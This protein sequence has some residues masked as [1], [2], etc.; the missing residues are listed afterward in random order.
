MANLGALSVYL[1]ANT[2]QF[3]RK[4]NRAKTGI[5]AFKV[6]AVAGFTAV[7]V[8]LA[9]MSIDAVKAFAAQEKAENKLRATLK[10]TG[11]AAGFTSKQL[12]KF[13]NDMQ[14]EIGISDEVLLDHITILTTFKNVSGEV[15][16]DATR[17]AQDMGAVMGVDAKSSVV[18]LGKALND[19]VK[20][21]SALSEVGVT[22]NKVQA[23]QIKKLQ[24]S[25]DLLGAQ[26]II[27]QELQTEFGGAAKAAADAEPW[28]KLSNSLGDVQEQLG[29]ILSEA[30]EVA[31]AFDSA[32]KSANGF[33]DFLARNARGIAVWIKT[34][35]VELKF[36]FKA[37]MRAGQVFFEN[38][39]T[40]IIAI[41]DAIKQVGLNLK[42]L[43]T[44][45]K[46]FFKS[47]AWKNVFEIEISSALKEISYSEEF[48]KI[49]AEKAKALAAISTE[50]FEKINAQQKRDV[51]EQRAV[52]EAK[53]TAKPTT[54]GATGKVSLQQQFAGALI[55][56]SSEAFS[57]IQ[58][59]GLPDVDRKIEQ[60]TAATAEAT[61]QMETGIKQ[62]VQAQK[63]M[64]HFM[65]TGIFAQ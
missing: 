13:A 27:L 11:F 33:V 59:A 32:D 52:V 65:R 54:P 58:S 63:E 53:T 3:N 2:V 17:V 41:V 46:Q 8:G 44:D 57:A 39:L 19:P 20:G 24:E 7:G 1:T 35:G 40:G 56:G 42:G 45:P 22:F 61:E 6:A 62:M 38:A 31:G 16:K 49:E 64:M 51:A 50:A 30:L 9:K 47:G 15:F 23:E 10:A 26:K 18:Q 5:T 37:G 43:F 12:A 36:G 14:R 4:M 34:I 21:V 48:A 29:G 60:N 55:K 25:G 28:V